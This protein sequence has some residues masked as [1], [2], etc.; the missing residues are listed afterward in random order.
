MRNATSFRNRFPAVGKLLSS[1][2][3]GLIGAGAAEPDEESEEEEAGDSA[4]QGNGAGSAR[5]A[6]ALQAAFEKDGEALVQAEKD[7]WNAVLS[8]D[9]GK[10]NVAGARNMLFKT[11]MDASDITETLK[12]MGPGSQT[13]PKGNLR[14]DAR[15]RLN[16]DEDADKDLGG[17]GDRGG[18][19][20]G[21]ESASERRKRMQEERNE[22]EASGLR[23]P[24]RKPRGGK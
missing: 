15:N 16:A 13:P 18:R 2:S 7:R 8:S 22:R 19:D 24:Q 21:G 17:S 14:E 3:F 10:A 4:A 12:E 23:G 11:D 6:A 20:A 5:Q 9:E 1:A